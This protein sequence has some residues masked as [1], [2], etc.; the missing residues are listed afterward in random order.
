ML[1]TDNVNIAAD[2]YVRTL[3]NCVG[4]QTLARLFTLALTGFPTTSSLN[5]YATC[6]VERNYIPNW[7]TEPN[8]S[9]NGPTSTNL[10]LNATPPHLNL[11]ATDS[12]D[13]SGIVSFYLRGYAEV[14][15]G[16]GP[17]ENP[18]YSAD[19]DGYGQDIGG[20]TSCG[21][22][23]STCRLQYPETVFLF[24]R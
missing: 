22:S 21:Y 6:N 20:P 10:S 19:G 2:R 24:V 1:F 8:W 18:G 3:N 5:Y 17:D 4:G 7:T 12:T 15:V 14:D 13:T 16:L 23:D 11:A 9:S